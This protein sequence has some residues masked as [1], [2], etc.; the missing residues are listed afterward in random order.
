MQQQNQSQDNSTT[1]ARDTAI[2]IIK[3]PAENVQKFCF[4]VFEN[5]ATTEEIEVKDDLASFQK[6]VQWVNKTY[7]PA[8]QDKVDILKRYANGNLT[9]IY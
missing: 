8:E 4:V 1:N 5:Y 7:T 6:A 3:T 2:Q 9:T